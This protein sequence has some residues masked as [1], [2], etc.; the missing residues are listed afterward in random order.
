MYKVDVPGPL[1]IRDPPGSILVTTSRK[2]PLSFST[3][4]GRLREVRLYLTQRT[5]HNLL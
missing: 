1:L 5:L 2:R 3:L 4:G